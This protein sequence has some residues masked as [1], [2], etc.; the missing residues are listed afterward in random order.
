MIHLPTTQWSIWL[1]FPF[2]CLQISFKTSSLEQLLTNFSGSIF[3][4]QAPAI[5]SKNFASTG[6]VLETMRFDTVHTLVNTLR[7]QK[8]GNDGLKHGGKDVLWPM[9]LVTK[10]RFSLQPRPQFKLLR[11]ENIRH[12]VFCLSNRQGQV[13]EKLFMNF[14]TKTS[15]QC[16]CLELQEMEEIWNWKVVKTSVCFNEELVEMASFYAVYTGHFDF[17]TNFWE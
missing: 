8:Y 9:S 17:E 1:H 6:F 4:L 16:C 7:V 10:G 13:L 14:E 15:K 2:R 5:S 12:L 3:S 11:R